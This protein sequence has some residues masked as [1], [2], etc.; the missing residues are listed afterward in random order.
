MNWRSPSRESEGRG[1]YNHGLR[2]PASGSLRVAPARRIAFDVLLTV[3]EGGLASDLLRERSAGLDSRDAGLAAEI[4]FGVLRYQ[5]QLDFLRDHFAGRALTA[6]PAASLAL[7]M[8]IYQLRYLDRIPPHAAVGES[9]ALVR[10]AGEGKAAGL[11]N[12][13]LRKVHRRP[14][15]WPNRAVEWS[16]PEWLLERWTRH[17]G[18]DAALGIA[19]ANLARPETYV[20]YTGQPPAGLEPAG[21]AGGYRCLGGPPPGARAQDIGAQSVV[22]LLDLRPG[23]RFLDLC[24]APGNKTAQARETG[25]WAVACDLHLRRLRGVDCPD[26]VQ[27]D[28]AQ[29]LPFLRCFDRVLVDA[30]CSGTGTLGRNPE[31][32]WRLRPA[33]L[34]AHR[35]RQTALL[36]RARAVLKPGGLLVYSTCSLEHEENEE[37]VGGPGVRQCYRIPGR[38]PG[39]GFYAAVVQSP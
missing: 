16:H 33:D 8:G 32:K 6:G 24:A 37:V 21:I 36:E 2:V 34:A 35:A 3:E 1:R 15:R 39:D 22:P 18:A 31:I 4:V 20:R 23:H 26:R 10:R 28:G 27:L 17:F 29:P 12:A 5:L 14:V 19:K 13:V 38:E 25:V 30:P 9:V 7:R 11:V